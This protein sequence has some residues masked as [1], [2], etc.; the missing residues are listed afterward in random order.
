M[1]FGNLKIEFFEDYIMLRE[2]FGMMLSLVT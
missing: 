2:E 1:Y